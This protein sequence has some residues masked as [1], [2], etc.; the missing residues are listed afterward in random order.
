M[1]GTRGMWSRLTHPLLVPLSPIRTSGSGSVSCAEPNGARDGTVTAR[2]GSTVNETVRGYWAPIFRILYRVRKEQVQEQ[3]PV[4]E[5]TGLET[6]K[7]PARK[8]TPSCVH[9]ELKASGLWVVR[10]DG[11]GTEIRLFDGQTTARILHIL[12]WM[13]SRV[14]GGD[15]RV[16]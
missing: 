16:R 15:G 13:D 14:D 9:V 10:L 4:V 6:V 11:P 7:P 8:V 3:M 1:K 5:A 2:R 12:M